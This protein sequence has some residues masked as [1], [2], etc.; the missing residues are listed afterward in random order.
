MKII[1]IGCL[2]LY[3][4][5]SFGQKT[6]T[7][8]AWFLAQLRLDSKK[9][10]QV[11]E[12]GHRRQNVFLT[13]HRQSLFRYTLT[14]QT[15]SKKVGLGGGIACFLH[16][17]KQGRELETET[18][19]FL[20]VAQFFPLKN[21]EFQ[22]RF[23]NEFRFFDRSTKDQDRLRV[24]LLFS[25]SLIPELRTKLSWFNEWFYS[26]GQAKPWEWRGGITIQQPVY[27]NWKV[28]IGYIYQ[29]NEGSAIR[30]IHVIQMSWF[31][32][33]LLN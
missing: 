5:A 7:T 29:N 3:S 18:R 30:N 8:N 25:H 24:Q 31:Y 6:S 21:K 20:Q 27:K 19:P 22:L 2:F 12:L 23:R 13:N 32:E 33:L 11:I 9:Y 4:F 14:Y 17:R 16:E 26:F 28:G 10:L 15:N 1:F